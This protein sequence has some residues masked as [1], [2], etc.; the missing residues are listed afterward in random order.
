MNNNYTKILEENLRKLF[1]KPPTPLVQALP[2][3]QTG[4]GFEFRAFGQDCEIRQSG[5][6]LGREKQTSINGILISL[7]ALHANMEPK[8]LEPFKAFKEFPNSMPY[9]GAF[10]T[11]TQNILVPHVPKINAK[12]AT[13]I[14]KLD[15]QDSFSVNSGFF[16]FILK[17][18]PKISLSYI[19]Y[20]PDNDFPASVTCL[21][22]NNAISFLP[23][24]ALADVGEYTS[25]EIIKLID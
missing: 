3:A 16:S 14:E 18:L 2:A 15:G 8:R 11:H 19:F 12:R 4:E 13:I 24:D 10:V 25:K 23:I 21:Y 5:I 7:Y 1:E 20:E 17:P 22:S 9:A 6:F